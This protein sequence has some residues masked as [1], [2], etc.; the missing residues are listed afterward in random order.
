[1]ET[2]LGSF[3]TATID[4]TLYGAIGRVTLRFEY[5]FGQSRAL[6]AF[7]D[8]GVQMK[9]TEVEYPE[10]EVTTQTGTQGYPKQTYDELLWGPYVK[11]GLRYAF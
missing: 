5:A 4:N 3:P 2:E 9:Y 7:I 11:V 6:R 8:G 10:W 1:M